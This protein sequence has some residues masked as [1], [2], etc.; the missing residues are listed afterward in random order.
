M[1]IRTRNSTLWSEQVRAMDRPAPWERLFAVIALAYFAKAF[2]PFT[3]GFEIGG[4]SVQGAESGNPLDQIVGGTIYAISL[5][6]LMRDGEAVR[7]ALESPVLSAFIALTIISVLWSVLPGV[8]IRRAVGLLGTACF[9]AYLACRFTPRE[10]LRMTAAAFGIVV[11]LSILIIVF[12]PSYGTVEGTEI[13]GVFGQ[14]NELGRAMVF[15]CLAIWTL[16][17]DAESRPPGWAIPALLAAMTLLLLTRSA[18]AIVGLAAAVIIVIPIL[19]LCARFFR[20][21]HI[22]LAIALLLVMS[23]VAFVVSAAAEELLG[24]LGRDETLTDRTLI[25][26]LLTEFGH[27]RPWLGRGYGAFWFSDVSLWFA[28]RWGALDHAH[29]GYM[30]LWLELGYVGVAAFVLLLLAASKATWNAYL[31]RPTAA[32]RFFPTF[33]A[34]AALINC[35]GRLM[36]AHNTIYWVILCYCAMMHLSSQR[37]WRYLTLHHWSL[38]QTSTVASRQS[39]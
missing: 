14:K 32:L 30:D 5:W 3:S 23:L 13:A 21:V 29:N 31:M 34:I 20:R 28:D 12:V 8:T 6:L 24:L 7:A 33:I 37:S 11:G 10:V 22:R 17:W 25:W 18:Q 4:Y 27:E 39:P 35:V 1:T 26:E 38:Q 16:I 36:P 2:A 15:A 19:V 9:G